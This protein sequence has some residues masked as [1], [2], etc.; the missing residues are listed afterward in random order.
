MYS[1]NKLYLVRE[2]IEEIENQ[3]LDSPPFGTI[4]VRIICK[5]D[6]FLR[7]EISRQ[8]SI[9]LAEQAQGNLEVS[10]ET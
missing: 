5:D 2:M 7:L 6:T 3:L 1:N 4:T 10:Y 9:L 8:V